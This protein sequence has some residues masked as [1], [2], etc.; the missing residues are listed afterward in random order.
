MEQLWSP[1]LLIITTNIFGIQAPFQH[2]E[3]LHTPVPLLSP[4]RCKAIVLSPPYCSL[5]D[6]HPIIAPEGIYTVPSSLVTSGGWGSHTDLLLLCLLDPDSQ[7]HP[8]FT[9]SSP[10][11][12]TSPGGDRPFK[13]PPSAPAAQPAEP[14]S[15]LLASGFGSSRQP[16]RRCLRRM[17]GG[18]CHG[19]AGAGLGC[20]V[21]R[22]SYVCSHPGSE[23]PWTGT[24]SLGRGS[25]SLCSVPAPV[26]PPKLDQIPLVQ[27]PSLPLCSSV[28]SSIKWR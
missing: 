8:A 21:P 19:D 11:G 12:R 15:A 16:R 1:T 23:T 26:F 2:P 4:R 20:R 22:K 5:G 24:C 7:A 9:I 14:A 13:S 27:E 25:S 28:S 18:C 3:V 10:R 6:S 17:C